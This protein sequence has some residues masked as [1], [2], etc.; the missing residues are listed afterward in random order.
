M[1]EVPRHRKPGCFGA[2]FPSF[3]QAHVVD[4]IV[5]RAPGKCVDE[6]EAILRQMAL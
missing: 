2:R 4:L 1:R 3:E 6:C 5:R